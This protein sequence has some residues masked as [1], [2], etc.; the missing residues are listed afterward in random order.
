M[1]ATGESSARGYPWHEALAWWQ[2]GVR[3]HMLEGLELGQ[4]VR[5][6]MALLF[7][8]IGDGE[9]A[10]KACSEVCRTALEKGVEGVCYVGRGEGMG[11]EGERVLYRNGTGDESGGVFIWG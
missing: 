1:R 8:D 7:W 6:G 2:S 5:D 11:R 10:V 9:M 3:R 4:M